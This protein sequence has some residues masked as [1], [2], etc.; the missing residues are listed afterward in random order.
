M[1]R[2]IPEPDDYYLTAGQLK[3]ALK[4]IPDDA[5]VLYQ[6]IEDMYFE[7]HGW[8]P[9]ELRW[10]EAGISDYIPV[11][12]CYKHPDENVFVLNAHY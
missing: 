4:N 11:F 6:R 7:N 2:K 3:A 5:I 10:E 12:S 1:K 8:E 9:I